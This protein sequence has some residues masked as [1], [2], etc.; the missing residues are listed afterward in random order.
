LVAWGIQESNVAEIK[1]RNLA[2]MDKCRQGGVLNKFHETMLVGHG[3]EFLM[4]EQESSI[5]ETRQR[6]NRTQYC[7]MVEMVVEVENLAQARISCPGAGM[8]EASIAYQGTRIEQDGRIW[9]L[10]EWMMNEWLPRMFMFTFNETL[11][12]VSLIGSDYGSVEE[13]GFQFYRTYYTMYVGK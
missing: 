3:V 10:E 11:R 12:V 8:C 5:N 2:R 1:V 13:Y 7:K 6:M 4:S 9:S